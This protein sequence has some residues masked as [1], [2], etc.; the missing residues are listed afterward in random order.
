MQKIMVIG[1][2]GAGKST[3]SKQIG[4]LKKLP[5]IHLDLLYWKP[6]WIESTKEEFAAK[7]VVALAGKKW[8]IDGNYG[9]TMEV[10]LK[11]A[12]AI[13]WLD[14]SI[15]LCFFRVLKRTLTN[16]GKTRSDMG[17]GC[18]E[19]F[20][21]EFLHYVLTFPFHARR[22]LVKHLKRKKEGQ[23]VFHLKNRKEVKRFLEALRE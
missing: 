5:V 13:V 7:Q 19:R 12:D 23:V 1:S 6:N 3:L 11:R 17:E 2:C 8:V 16:Y 22:R 20:D 10:R 14:L 18:P 9:G 21:L 15:P 4:E